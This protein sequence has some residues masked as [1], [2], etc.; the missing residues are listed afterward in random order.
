[1]DAC[2]VVLHFLPLQVV[3]SWN[4]ISILIEAEQCIWQL[5]GRIFISTTD[6]QIGGLQFEILF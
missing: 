2:E 5:C 3:H 1:M 6:V 4:Y